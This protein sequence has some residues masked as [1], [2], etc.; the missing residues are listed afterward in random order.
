MVGVGCL[1]MVVPYSHGGSTQHVAAW[2]A[3]GHPALSGEGTAA[4][5]LLL[6][7]RLDSPASH[8]AGPPDVRDRGQAH[9]PPVDLRGQPPQGAGDT[10]GG[11]AKALVLQELDRNGQWPSGDG[12]HGSIPLERA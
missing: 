11:V 12:R 2:L 6:Q 3:G 10:H 1:L 7:L 9:Q 4:V 8:A 5:G